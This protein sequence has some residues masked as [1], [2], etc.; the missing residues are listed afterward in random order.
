LSSDLEHLVAKENKRKKETSVEKYNTSIHTM[1][2]RRYNEVWMVCISV[3]A[4]PDKFS[5]FADDHGNVYFN[6]SL[7]TGASGYTVYWCHHHRHMNRCLV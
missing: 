2:R 1:C 3:P 4:K 6:W 7:V 5:V